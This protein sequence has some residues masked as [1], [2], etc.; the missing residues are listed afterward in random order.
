MESYLAKLIEQVNPLQ[1]VILLLFGYFYINKSINGLGLRI[2]KKFDEVDKRFNE[3]DKKFD[4]VEKRFN[5][6]ESKFDE[7]FDEAQ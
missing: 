6:L 7:K 5:E 1:I 3:I 2:D 4:E